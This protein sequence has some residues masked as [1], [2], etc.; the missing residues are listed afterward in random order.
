MLE[1]R[2]VSKAYRTGSEER[3]V[4]ADVDLSVRA[5]ESLALTGPSGAGKSTVIAIAGLVVVPDDGEVW[6]AGRPAPS[7]TGARARARNQ[8]LGFVFQ[9]Y[10]LMAAESVV[11]NIALPLEY[12][13]PT[14]RRS[15]RLRRAAETAELVGIAHLLRR[16]AGT[17][18]G[19]EQ[20]RVSVARALVNRPNLVIADEPTAALDAENA[21]AVVDCL[22]DLTQQGV[23][24][25]VATHDETLSSRCEKFV[26][27]REGRVSSV[28]HTTVGPPTG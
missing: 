27:L 22:L 11:T 17:L 9:D 18:S 23:G 3:E 7:A 26:A 5:G 8:F 13:R 20:Q 1:L 4:V 21:A 10:A 14:V 19:G 12:A 25:L 28:R 6:L 24:L 2:A 15:E 16:R